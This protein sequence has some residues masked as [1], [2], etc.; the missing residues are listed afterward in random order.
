MG[1]GLISQKEYGSP[2]ISVNVEQVGHD[3]SYQSDEV[4]QDKSSPD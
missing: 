2:Y 4:K 3:D 1:S